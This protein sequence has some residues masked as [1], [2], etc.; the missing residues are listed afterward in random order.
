MGY[1]TQRQK[2][3]EFLE[4]KIIPFIKKRGDIDY[5]KLIEGMVNDLGVSKSMVE[6]CIKTYINNNTITEHRVLTISK[7]EVKHWLEELSKEEKQIKEDLET[8]K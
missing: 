4:K 6:D 1:Q 2:I 8:I 5:Y 7:E 3:S